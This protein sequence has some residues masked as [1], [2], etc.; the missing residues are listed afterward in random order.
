M[1]KI[2]TLLFS[3]GAFATS[4]AQAG[5]QTDYKR[6]DQYVAAKSNNDYKKF[7]NHR[8]YIYTFSAKEKDMEIAKINNDFNFKVKSII[9]NRRIKKYEKKLLIQKAQ[10]EKEQQIQTVNLKFNSKFNTAFNEHV[11]QFDKHMH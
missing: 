11:K 3:V 4:F 1:K 2:F 5:H 9:S 7:D 6:N 8:D 10:S